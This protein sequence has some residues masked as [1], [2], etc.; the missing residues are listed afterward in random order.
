MLREFLEKMLYVEKKT[1][2]SAYINLM[3]LE[4]T[5]SPNAT[6]YIE[7]ADSTEHQ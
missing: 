6:T 5:T 2:Y 4:R 1:I 3:G 7:E